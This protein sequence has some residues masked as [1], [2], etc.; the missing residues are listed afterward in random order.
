MYPKEYFLER[1]K[2]EE[3]EEL[4]HRYAATDLADEAKEA[5][6]SLLQSRGVDDSILQPL[7]IQARKAAYRQTKGT[8]ECDFCGSSAR[9]SA[10]LDEGQRFCSKS[11]LRSARLLEA[12]E[13]IPKEAIF[14]HACRIKEGPCPSCQRT[15]TRIEVRPYYRVWSVGLFTQ[16]TKRT[17]ICC[18]SCGRKTNLESLIFS[19]VLGWWGIPWGL[20]ITPG[21]IIA[22]IT[23][24][25]RSRG[26]S[27]PSAELIQAARLD[28]AARRYKERALQ[29]N[30]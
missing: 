10:V 8:T 16:W 28:L 23:E 3:T 15:L 6:R 25:L 24:M 7:V 26:D 4:L 14:Q 22:N 30:G 17:H 5:I 27:E 20:I 18:L 1:F 29:S 12:S 21:Q 19:V 2:T 9:F 13:D 11:C